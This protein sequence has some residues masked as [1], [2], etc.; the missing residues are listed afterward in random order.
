MYVNFSFVVTWSVAEAFDVVGDGILF[1]A[2][3]AGGLEIRNIMVMRWNGILPEPLA[4]SAITDEDEI[5]F[6]NA[7]L[8]S[9]N[10]ESIESRQ[11]TLKT[12]FTSITTPL[13]R[14]KRVDFAT[15]TGKRARFMR[16]DVRAYFRRDGYITL[17]LRAIK[18]GRLHGYSEN[19]GEVSIELG[20]LRAI[21]FNIYDDLTH[22]EF[23]QLLF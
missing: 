8:A 15:R 10:I 13:S 16:D 18:D 23:D 14:I 20:S 4:V 7:D 11:L 9:G 3:G 17:Q 1:Q 6:K 22:P 12:Q 5:R 21:R 19:I 2:Q